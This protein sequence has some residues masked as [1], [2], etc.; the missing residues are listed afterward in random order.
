MR[1]N[2]SKKIIINTLAIVL[3]LAAILVSVMSFYMKNLTDTIMQ[4]VLPSTIKTT[5]QSIEGSIHM[6]AD[7]IFMIGDNEF[8]TNKNSS[9]K[10]KQAVL[11]TAQSGIEFVW[12]GL[13]DKEG[14]LLFGNEKCPSSIADRTMFPLL[15]ETQ[16]LVI[17]DVASTD[18]A[19]ELA[20]GTPILAEK[21]LLYYLV[22][23]YKYDVLNDV[24]SNINL[25]AGSTAYVTNASGEIM[26]TRS[27][28]LISEH[29]SLA[30]ST[31]LEGITEKIT[32]GEIGVTSLRSNYIGYAP[33]NG[34]RW[35]LTI[36]VPQRDF[37]EP[38]DRSI[39]V[40]IIITSILLFLAILF[41]LR[42][43]SR[44]QKSLKSVTGRITL[45]AGGDLKT[46]TKIIRTKD[47]T[48][49][50]ST[51]LSNTI[52]SINGY[53]SELSEILENMS[54][55][56]FKLE[57][58][59][60]YNG[61]HIVIK[62]SLNRIIDSLNKML[63]SIQISSGEVF[64]TAGIVS[65]SANRVYTGSTEQSNSLNL[66]S[67]EI[68]AIEQN[69][70][71]VDKNTDLVSSLVSTANI[72]IGEGNENMDELLSSMDEIS[73]NSMEITKI[74]EILESISYQTNLLALNAS[75][76]AARAGTAG[77]GFSVV[78][79]E[80]RNLAERSAD[81]SKRTADIISRSIQA[82][83]Q[84][85]ES[86]QKA[87]ESFQN[88][89]EV[90]SQITT[91]TSQLSESVTIQKNSLTNV[92]GQIIQIRDFA[93]QNLDASYESTSAS[94]KLNAQAKEL[95]QISASF[96]LREE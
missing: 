66:L 16:N 83:E 72:S 89:E 67:D 52:D 9:N 82:V 64:Q 37:M 87:A 92:S 2:I 12:L 20:V 31:G 24:I 27:T 95:R 90:T 18:G 81:S 96:Q 10:E 36:I 78:A 41:T 55:G 62:E 88:I 69:I 71:D 32:S 14:K 68:D 49:T 40:S 44:I 73:R 33:I 19:L 47:E 11:D 58:G 57:V 51:A 63:K 46:P 15:R 35:Y 25:S 94:Q 60:E 26:G 80:V 1:R 85:T 74:N 38:A 65:D 86:A 13:Y 43:S 45:L 29:A 59:G 17:D 34:T 50:L 42:F 70:Q 93:Q 79:E 53:I 75:V 48:E 84:G 30:E 61:A 91:I 77:A 6:L 21:D 4:D 3:L 54:H 76:E 7:R 56:N 39:I 5:S 22:G 8:I 23:S 28:D